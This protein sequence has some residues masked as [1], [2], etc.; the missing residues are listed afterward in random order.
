VAKHLALVL[1]LSYLFLLTGLSLVNIGKLPTL[2]SSFDD[3]IFHFLSHALL[4]GLCFNY[5]Y[6]AKV[7][8]PVLI[9]ALVSICY[10]ISIEWLQSITSN[11]RTSDVYDIVSN[12]LGMIFAIIFIGTLKNVKLK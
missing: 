3:K 12:I 7:S 2:G 4:T 5:F 10:G 9:S 8:K 11:S 6:R 1:L